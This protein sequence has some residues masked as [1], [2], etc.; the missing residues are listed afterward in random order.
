MA[1]PPCFF[2][3][4]RGGVQQAALHPLFFR[5]NSYVLVM[6]EICCSKC[7]PAKGE[8]GNNGITTE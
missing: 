3:F 2:A 6:R 5:E 7:E 1:F 4:L 8:Y